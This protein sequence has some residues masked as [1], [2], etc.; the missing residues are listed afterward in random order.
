M[1]K[2]FR[3]SKHKVEENMRMCQ[4]LAMQQR[5]YVCLCKV[6]NRLSTCTRSGEV[7][8]GF[9]FVVKLIETGCKMLKAQP[10]LNATAMS[11]TS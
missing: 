3:G 9:L 5:D 10:R 1:L 11:P 6:A 2:A 7:L 4:P 8:V